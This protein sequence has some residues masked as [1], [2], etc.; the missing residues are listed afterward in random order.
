M[1][2]LG[3][4]LSFAAIVGLAVVSFLVC[5][6]YHEFTRPVA[7][8]FRTDPRPMNPVTTREM[9]PVHECSPGCDK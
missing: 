6:I 7:L 9:S 4:M 5:F 8:P 3:D 1:D 2:D